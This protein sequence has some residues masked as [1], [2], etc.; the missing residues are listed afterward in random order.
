MTTSMYR[1]FVDDHAQL[2][3]EELSRAICELLATAGLLKPLSDRLMSIC[4]YTLARQLRLHSLHELSLQIVLRTEFRELM[5]YG[6]DR[7]HAY[8]S[9]LV[10][11]QLSSRP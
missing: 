11:S 3:F 8:V 2:R 10:F 7:Q 9:L 1:Q 6:G 5:I 4:C